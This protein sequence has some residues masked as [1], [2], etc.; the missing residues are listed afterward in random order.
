MASK[1]NIK[2]FLIE[3]NRINEKDAKKYKEQMN[4]ELRN[5]KKVKCKIKRNI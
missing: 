5:N 2:V 1:E 4:L 3:K